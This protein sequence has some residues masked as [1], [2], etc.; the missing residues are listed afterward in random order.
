[1]SKIGLYIHIPFCLSKCPYCDFYSVKYDKNTAELYQQAVIR[2]IHEYLSNDN[3]LKFDTVYFGGG[4]PILLWKEICGIMNE[5]SD[6]LTENAEITLEANPCC[7]TKEALRSLIENGVNRISF[8]LQSGIDAELKALGRRH[9]SNCGKQAV[10]DAADAGFENISGDIML[11][12]PFQNC[13]SLNDT[14]RYMTSLPLSH[15][16]A[17]MLKIEGSTPFASTKLNLPDEDGYADIYL[18]TVQSLADKGF[19]QYEISNFAKNG[20]ESRHNLKYWRCEEYIGIGPS[21]HSYYK[22]ERFAVSRDINAFISTPIQQTVITEC[23]CGGFGEWA[24]LKLRLTEGIDFDTTTNI[25]G[26]SKDRIL[27][28]CRLIPEN[29]YKSDDK[30]IRLTPEGFLVSNAIIC[31][32]TDI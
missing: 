2:N 9:D 4:T 11:G 5:L 24:M 27:N 30:S 31:I 25:F 19:Y 32:L 16:S 3:D 21:A 6:Y 1:M 22:G 7:T 8:G 28:K 23:E 13:E 10:L 17:Y 26:V 29:L 12:I 20:Y 18:N 15:I 14:I